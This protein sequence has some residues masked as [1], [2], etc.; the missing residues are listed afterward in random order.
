MFS[1]GVGEIIISGGYIHINAMGDGIDSNN[2]ILVSS[3]VTLVSGSPSS[4]NAAFDYDG[5][6]T[7][8]GGIL[9]ATGGSGMAQSFSAAENQGCLL[10]GLSSGP[11]G[12]NLA[13]VNA[14]GRI[15][16][17]YTPGNNY[18][19]VVVTAPELQVGNTYTVVIDAVIDS[20]DTHGFATDTTYTGGTELGAIEMTTSLQGGSGHSMGGGPGGGRKPGR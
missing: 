6:A 11:A 17:A 9:I 2:T 8:T 15:V 12:R 20:A 7:V 18:S 14:D 5:E 10:F 13:I 4:G 1:N 3:G 19:A 16:A